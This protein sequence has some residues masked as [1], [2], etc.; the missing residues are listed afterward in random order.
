MRSRI[1]NTLAAAAVAAAITAGSAQAADVG[2]YGSIST[3][4]AFVHNDKLTANGIV[5]QKST[6]SVSMESGFFGDSIWGITGEEVLGNGWK[7]GFTLENE[8]SSDT[9]RL[10]TDD[11]IFDS[12][13]Y[14]KIGNDFVTFAAGNVGGLAS[15]GGD[16]DLV[17]GFDPMEAYLGVGGMGAFATR[18]YA[19]G[20][21]AVVEVTPM[22]GLR[23]S[24]MASLGEDDSTAEWHNRTHYYGI[25]ATYEAGAL[26]VAGV[27]EMINFDSKT[28]TA[29]VND[30]AMT[31]TIALS[32]DFGV[33]KPSFVYQHADKMRAFQ[34]EYA[35]SGAAY[36]FDS[37]LVGAAA[38]MGENGSLRA[39]VQYFT[40]ENDADANDDASAT[41][42]ALAYAHSLSKRTMLWTG[43]TYA[44][45]DDGLKADLDNRSEFSMG[46]DRASYNGFAFGLGLTHTF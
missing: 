39:S 43:A 46:L 18:D 10:A 21:T 12:Q 31:Y 6:D 25:G 24:A 16:F 14:L 8:F 19:S 1:H 38:P 22:E 42:L 23:I 9:G 45:G 35:D 26:A 29:A 28:N 32:Y 30:D 2:L 13:S 11:S 3:G 44:V 17:V 41:I 33:V 20:N 40:A 27:V 15:A 7:V 34:G 5:M 4:M 36:N 37:F